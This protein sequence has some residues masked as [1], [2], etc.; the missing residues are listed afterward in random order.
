[1]TNDELAARVIVLEYMQALLE[2]TLL[3]NQLA[4]LARGLDMADGQILSTSGISDDAILR[5]QELLGQ[6]RQRILQS[7]GQ[8]ASGQSQ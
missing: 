2:A 8:P 4:A 1:M 7:L 3:P 6:K 5:A